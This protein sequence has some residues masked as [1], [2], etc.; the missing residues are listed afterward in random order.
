MAAGASAFLLNLGP[1]ARVRKAD[2]SWQV[3]RTCW[4]FVPA[5]LLYKSREIVD[6]KGYR[7][8]CLVW[9][10]VLFFL[11][12]HNL[13]PSSKGPQGMSSYLLK[14]ASEVSP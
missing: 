12:D 6:E 4:T 3:K 13:S 1:R 2:L 8:A 11:S 14:P 5:P 10:R 9:A 7:D